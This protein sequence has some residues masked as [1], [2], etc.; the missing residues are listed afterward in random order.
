MLAVHKLIYEQ[1]EEGHSSYLW[2]WEAHSRRHL[3][4]AATPV[5]ATLCTSICQQ[6]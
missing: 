1:E 2:Y 4:S 3:P 6:W 5:D